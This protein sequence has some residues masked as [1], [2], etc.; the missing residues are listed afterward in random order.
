MLL[1]RFINIYLVEKG[2]N[3]KW[4]S[5][6]TD[7]A[8]MHFIYTFAYTQSLELAGVVAKRTAKK[9]NPL[10]WNSFANGISLICCADGTLWVRHFPSN[11]YE[12]LN[13]Q[14]NMNLIH[15]FFAFHPTKTKTS[16]SSLALAN[17][18]TRKRCRPRPNTCTT[19]LVSK[20]ICRCVRHFKL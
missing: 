7:R 1:K 8:Q 17:S 2:R 14:E 3:N 5:T 4:A 6:Y 11:F 9:F 13:Y 15:I 20:W 10:Y 19:L 12:F 18:F 16:R